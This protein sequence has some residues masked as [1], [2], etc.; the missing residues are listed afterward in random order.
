[1]LAHTVLSSVFSEIL[2]KYQEQ[3]EL[4][5]PHLERIVIPMIAQLREGHLDTEARHGVFRLLYIVTKVR[6]YKAVVKCFCHEVTDLHPVLDELAS[7]RPDDHGRWQT[8]YILLLWMSM[9][10]LV[11]FD[12]TILDGDNAGTGTPPISLV[13]QDTAICLTRAVWAILGR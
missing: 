1:M 7:L 2:E 10:C 5:D 12:M 11:P 6:G 8:R 3:P 13:E 4:L 9:I